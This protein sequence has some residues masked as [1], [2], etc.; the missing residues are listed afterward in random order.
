M[1]GWLFDVYPDY[2]KNRMVCWLKTESGVDKI[3]DADYFP[4]FYVHGEKRRLKEIE[5]WLG[6]VPVRDVSFERRK[7]R[8]G[9][10]ELFDVLSVTPATYSDLRYLAGEIDSR[11][12]YRDFTLYNVDIRLS[13]RYTMEKGVFPM[14]FLE[15]VR[16]FILLDEQWAIHYDIPRLSQVE[17]GVKVHGR[18]KIKRFSDSIHSIKLGDRIVRGRDEREML[19]ELA[20]RMGMVDPDVVLTRNGDSFLFPYLYGRAAENDVLEEFQ[21]GR[22]ASLVNPHREGKSYFSYGRILYRPPKYTLRGRIHIDTGGSFLHMESGLYGLID[23]ARISN[24]PPQE[25]AKLSPGTAVSAMQVNQAMRDGHPVMWKKNLPEEFKTAKELL[26]CDKGGFIFEPKVG[27]HENV[28]EIDFTSLYPSIMVRFNISPETVLCECC[29]DSNHRVPEIGYHVCEKKIGLIP[30]VLS[31]VI[32]RRMVFKRLAKERGEKRAKEKSDILKWLLVCSFGYT[33]YR[34]ARY[35]KIEC[36]ESITAYGREILLKSAE[37]ADQ[38]GFEV[39]HGIVD[40][41]WLKGEGDEQKLIE[42]VSGHIGIPVEREG[43][44]K[45]IVFLPC[46]TFDV[47]AM[48]RYYGMFEDGKMKIRGIEARR[49]DTCELVKRAQ[50]EMLDVF[51]KAESVKEFKE[52]VPEALEVLRKWVKRVRK[53]DIDLEDL[54]LTLRISKSLKE[55]SVFNNQ[56][57]ALTQLKEEDVKVHPGEVIRFVLLDSE[58][59][60]AD[61]RLRV[62]DLLEG[63]ETY[64]KEKYIELLCRMGETLLQPLDYNR[65]RIAGLMAED[66]A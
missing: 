66:Q 4:N 18:S 44:Y 37:I 64:D 41:L 19:L 17:M 12:R 60:I 13:Q 63:G 50:M 33:G 36:H 58:S 61:E 8:L 26:V 46:K 54:I 1:R 49:H 62:A 24:I 5:D 55:Y 52:N 9:S 40:S 22:E 42:H 57:A 15:I 39:L 47:G 6:S 29:P 43:V 25:I 30:R 65:K 23:L 21:L 16:D 14:A 51:A 56:V 34:N 20:Q 28:L 3:V 38:H 10:Q 59:K 11:G 2:D 27:L 7:L 31:P 45:W 48:N 35:G 32:R 53:E